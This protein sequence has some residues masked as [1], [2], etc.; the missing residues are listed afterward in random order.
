MASTCVCCW[1]YRLRFFKNKEKEAQ[2]HFIQVFEDL[3][4]TNVRYALI[5]LWK[6][7]ASSEVFGLGGGLMTYVWWNHF[8]QVFTSRKISHSP[9]LVPFK[10]SLS[11]YELIDA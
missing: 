7:A 8:G 1:F 2:L 10:D 11:N 9:Q 4:L 3:F 6:A 5:L